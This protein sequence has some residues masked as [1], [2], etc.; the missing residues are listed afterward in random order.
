MTPVTPALGEYFGTDRGLLVLRVAE[1]AGLPLQEGDVLLAIGG[2]EPAS[3][4]QA[5]RILASYEPGET[6]DLAVMRRGRRERLE[7]RLPDGDGGG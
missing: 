1:D 2:R 7:Y 5:L 4:G 3:P 6:V